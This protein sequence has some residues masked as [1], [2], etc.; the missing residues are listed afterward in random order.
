MLPDNRVQTTSG[1]AGSDKLPTRTTS[2]ALAK[3]IASYSRAGKKP[4]FFRKSFF[5]RYKGFL[6]VFKFFKGFFRFQCPNK[7]GHKISTREEHP[8]HNA[9]SFLAFSVKYNKTHK[10]QLKYEI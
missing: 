5:L 7:T 6:K 2:T 8:I 1:T 4:W 9:L 10:S 3:K